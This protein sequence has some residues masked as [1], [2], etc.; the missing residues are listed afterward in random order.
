MPFLIYEMTTAGI[1][2]GFLGKAVV[3]CARG[4]LTLYIFSRIVQ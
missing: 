1:V 2:S 4:M 3:G